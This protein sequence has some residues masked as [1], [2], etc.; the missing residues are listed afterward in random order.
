MYGQISIHPC[1][2]KSMLTHSTY[3]FPEV[4]TT[5]PAVSTITGELRDDNYC[6][7]FRGPRHS[8]CS[9]SSTGVTCREPYGMTAW[10][11][12]VLFIFIFKS[13][14][15]GCKDRGMFCSKT[16]SLTL[17]FL[18]LHVILRGHLLIS[19]DW[20]EI[21]V[22]DGFERHSLVIDGRRDKPLFWCPLSCPCVWTL[23]DVRERD[24][25]RE[26]YGNSRK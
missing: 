2:Y 3:Y 4:S 14:L 1:V 12:F 17:V 19:T 26:I 22:E 8:F 9:V 24:A 23:C 10:F 7:V 5:A 21:S 15:I 18:C 16:Q 25:R 11:K 13:V 20:I 6:W